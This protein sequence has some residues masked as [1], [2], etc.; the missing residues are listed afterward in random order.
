MGTIK[1]SDLSLAAAICI[2]ASAKVIKVEN[3]KDSDTKKWFVLES[4][5]HSTDVLDSLATSYF[6]SEL[7]VEVR[8]YSNKVKALKSMLYS[9]KK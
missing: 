4:Q 5:F 1:T 2:E 9:I 3:D 7:L 8:S 6:N